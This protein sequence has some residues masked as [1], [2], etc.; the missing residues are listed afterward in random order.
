MK[1]NEK[2]KQVKEKI[3]V[4]DETKNRVSLTMIF[5][6]AIA[7]VLAAAITITITATF[8]FSKLGWFTAEKIDSPDIITLVIGVG[9]ISIIIG[10]AVALLAM[11]HPLKPFNQIITQMNRLAA[12]DFKARLHFSKSV[13]SYPAFKETS[14]SFNK[15]AEELE[16]SQLLRSDFINN[17]S[18]EFKTPIVSIAGFAKLLKRDDLTEE[19]RKEYINIIEEESL[20]LASMATNTLNLTK[21]ENQS[22]LTEVS[23]FNLTEQIRSCILLLEN[24][25]AKKNIEP[26][27]DMDEL[28]V[29]GNEELLKQV[30]INLIDNAI[31]FSPDNSTIEITAEKK[32]REIILCFR[33]QGEIEKDNIDKIF[34]KF[35]QADESHSKEGNGVG[36]AIAKRIVTLHNGKIA[37]KSENNLTEFFITLPIK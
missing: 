33:N 9:L 26:M 16:G 6:V 4:K 14:E 22:I 8:V 32:Q 5:S 36:L 1:H 19:Q 28:S 15:M 7:I 30:W 13:A 34:N 11:K 3:K 2:L 17:I 12:G 37:V 18:H 21:V 24:K 25:W 27:L 10:F 29:S 23:N 20:R 31:K 35:Y